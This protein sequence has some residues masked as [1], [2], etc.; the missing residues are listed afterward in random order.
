MRAHESNSDRSVSRRDL[1][2]FAGV[3]GAGTLLTG[4]AASAVPPRLASVLSMPSGA[5]D[6]PMSP[7]LRAA[8]A[9]A[10]PASAV[11]TRMCTL[12]PQQ[13]EGPYYVNQRLLRRNI[14]EGKP[15]LPLLLFFLVVRA[16]DCS[17][18]QGAIVDVWHDDA[19][20]VYSGFAN[21][22]TAGQTF[23]RGVQTTDGIGLAWF[24]TIYPGWYPGRTAHIHFK[25]H[26]QNQTA[27]TSQSYFADGVTD[28]VYR[29]LPPYN[30][31]G[32]RNTRN[33]NDGIYDA[34][35]Q[36]TIMLAPDGSLQL[37]GGMIIGIA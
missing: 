19:L 24:E 5:V 32:P 12:T 27:V 3:A 14:T 29:L 23:L 31:R 17:P 13:T 26:L 34:R 1:L 11:L 20:G 16:S 36:K 10:G 7:A 6:A 21:Q 18:V 25:V 8:A 15:G 30:T 22:G 28:L 35:N 2:R 33:T 4:N 37:W 9:A